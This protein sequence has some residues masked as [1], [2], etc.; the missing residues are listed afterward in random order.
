MRA[1]HT[2]FFLILFFVACI[3]VKED[4]PAVEYQCWDGTIVSD[5][6]DCPRTTT[7]KA[8]TTTTTTTTTT[9]TEPCEWDPKSCRMHCSMQCGKRPLEYCI[10]NETI[11]RC[12]YKCGTTTKATTTTSTTLVRWL[13]EKEI[14]EAIVWGED[15]KFTQENLLK[16]YAYPNYSLGYEHVI[17]YTPYLNLALLAGTRARE[18]QEI[19]EAEINAIT[20]SNE[21]TFRVK[22]YGN[23]R[24]FNKNIKAVI[25]LRNEIMYPTKIKVDESPETT[26]VWPNQPAYFA[27]NAYT[28]CDYDKIRNRVIR[29]IVIKASGED[30]YTIDMSKY[31]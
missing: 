5:L 6:K 4:K 21:I 1:P 26:D 27:V 20:S 11:C 15:N 2:A 24:E 25:K 14:D 31:K 10:L 9:S 30:T 28:F 23:T 8:T 16:A 18:Y 3:E 12:Q 22:L 17:V 7:T 19:S 13:T 29:F